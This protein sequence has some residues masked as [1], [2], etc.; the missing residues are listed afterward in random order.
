MLILRTKSYKNEYD[1][2]LKMTAR[3][4]MNNTHKTNLYMTY[5]KTKSPL[6]ADIIIVIKYYEMA[7]ILRVII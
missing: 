3:H 7:W 5:N 4:L 6:M 1:V 2:T